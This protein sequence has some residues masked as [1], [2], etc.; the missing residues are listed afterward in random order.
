MIGAF[1]V[2]STVASGVAQAQAGVWLSA[3]AACG[4]V[5]RVTWGWLADRRDGRLVGV[6]DGPVAAVTDGVGVDLK[7]TPHGAGD[8]GFEFG[9]G[10]EEETAVA[11][12]VFVI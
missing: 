7:A 2:E 4:I 3:G 5:A 12:V 6:E 8:D 1:F 10:K 9:L 11:V